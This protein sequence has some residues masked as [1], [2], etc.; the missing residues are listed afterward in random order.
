[1][2]RIASAAFHSIASTV[3][4]LH[5]R[6]VLVLLAAAFV[7]LPYVVYAQAPAGRLNIQQIGDALTSYGK[8]TVSSNGQ[9]YYTVNCGHGQWNSSVVISL[10]PNGN[11]IWMTID[12]A[13]IDSAHTSTAALAGILKKNND[14]GPMFFSINGRRLRLSYPIP[15]HDLTADKV[16]AYVEAIVNTAVD[17]MPLWQNGSPSGD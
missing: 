16:K 1:M 14:I 15:N 11:V 5:T 8:N 12:P 6:A 4:S 10:S 3:R 2:T 17:T 13:P 7:L 9:T